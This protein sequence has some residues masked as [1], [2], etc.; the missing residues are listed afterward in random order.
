MG[1]LHPIIVLVA[2]LI[3]LWLGTRWVIV[4]ALALSERYRLSHAFVGLAILAIGTDLPEVFVS[5][6]ASLLHLRG[7]ESSGIITGNAIGSCMAQITVILGIVALFLTAQLD[8]NQLYFNGIFLLLSIVVVFLLGADG[9]INRL[10]GGILL[11]TYAVYY[12]LLVKRDKTPTEGEAHALPSLS[13]TLLFLVVG[14]LV[15]IV[16]S[17]GVVDSAM[18]LASVWGLEQSFVG[19]AFI[20]LGTS[21]PELAVSLGAALRRATHLSVS[22]IIGSNVFDSLVPIGLGGAI[23]TT[24]LETTLW[25]F[26][27]PFLFGATLLTLIFLATKKGLAGW[28]GSALILVYLVYIL[29]KTMG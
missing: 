22:N 14:I 7:V 27:L 5:V 21:L 15:L 24:T 16:S 26:D 12:V 28:E 18:R 29:I 19:I 13:R 10:E 4:G 17:H 9:I 25:Q 23:S 1:G 2:G 6:D 11:T 3:G 20:G 8:R